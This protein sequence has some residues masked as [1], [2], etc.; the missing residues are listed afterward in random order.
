MSS[1]DRQSI[2]GWGMFPGYSHDNWGDVY[3]SIASRPAVRDKVFELAVNYIRVEL[4]SDSYSATGPNNLNTSALD[5]LK[6]HI[7]MAQ[8]KG[9][10]NWIVSVW[11]PPAP[12]KTPLQ[13]TRGKVGSTITYFN[14]TYVEQ[15]CAY[16][17]NALKYLQNNGCG[18]PVMISLQNEPDYPVDYD[19][20]SYYSKSDY[21]QVV[22]RMRYWLD[23][24]GLNS[25]RIGGPEPGQPGDP[26]LLGTGTNFWQDLPSVPVNDVIA[27]TYGGAGWDH[28]Q[29]SLAPIPRWITEWCDID[30]DDEINAAVKSASHIARDVLNDGVGK[31]LY[32]NTYNPTT[33]PGSSDVVYGSDTAPQTTKLFHVLKRLFKEVVPDSSF[34]VRSFTSDDTDFEVGLGSDYSKLINVVGFQSSSKTVIVL[35]N[36]SSSTKTVT[37]HG[38]PEGS[39]E[40]FQTSSSTSS[41]TEMDDLGSISVSGGASAAFTIAPTT[42][43]ILTSA[44]ASFSGIPLGWYKLTAEFSGKCLDVNGASTATGANVQQ[45]T[46]NGTSAQRWEIID[47]GGGYYKLV[48]QCSG[49]CLDVNQA[50]DTDGANVQQWDDNGTDAQK[51]KFIANSDGS[52]HLVPKCAES[53]PR[54]LDVAGYSYSDGANVAIWQWHSGTNQSWF[55]TRY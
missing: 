23:S 1:S 3:R 39:L 28:Y 42:V 40:I 44:P 14:M 50:A 27:H 2:D 12:Y 17:A 47:V 4:S 35:T 21:Q 41:S 49:K 11:S 38:I 48:A 18:T 34:K 13:D 16:Y 25:V 53:T 26:T 24:L 45:W 7:Q 5:E 22:T 8:G 51:W 37:L 32:W 9:V 20:C 55:L 6:A 33:T 52:Y 19:G 30:G 29:F 36:T 31:W 54:C 10:N 15:F 43:Q 46:D